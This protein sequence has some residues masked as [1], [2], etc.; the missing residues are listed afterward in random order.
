MSS[1]EREFLDAIQAKE[2]SG[3]YFYVREIAKELRIPTKRAI[4]ICTK[5]EHRGWYSYGVGILTGWLTT[6]GLDA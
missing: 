2:K 3:Q 4:Y 6:E 5:W 1:D